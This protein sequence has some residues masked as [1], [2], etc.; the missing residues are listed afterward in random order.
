[1]DITVIRKELIKNGDKCIYFSKEY[2]VTLESNDLDM[3]R[4]YYNQFN[5]CMNA[6]KSLH[7]INLIPM[8]I[9]SDFRSLYHQYEKDIYELM[10]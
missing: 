6:V 8:Y 4:F 9:Y 7:E 2:M 3:Q 10:Y 1:M 5:E